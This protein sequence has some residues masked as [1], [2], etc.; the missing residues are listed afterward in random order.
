MPDFQYRL[1]APPQG[2]AVA[3]MGRWDSRQDFGTDTDR[4][5]MAPTKALTMLQQSGAGSAGWDTLLS[6]RGDSW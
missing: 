1:T 4:G 6:A 5:G 3:V 2:A